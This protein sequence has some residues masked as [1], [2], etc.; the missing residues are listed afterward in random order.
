MWRQFRERMID[1]ALEDAGEAWDKVEDRADAVGNRAS[2][3]WGRIRA[4]AATW[5][6]KP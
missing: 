6:R 2:G 3:L 1:P 4:W 5:R